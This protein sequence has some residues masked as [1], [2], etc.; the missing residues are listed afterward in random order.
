MEIKSIEKIENKEYPKINEISNKRLK[1]SI[2]QKWSRLGISIFIFNLI[3]KNKVF[4]SIN[5]NSLSDMDV[6][7]G[8][9]EVY[10]PTPTIV[11]FTSNMSFIISVISLM[12]MIIQKIKIKKQKEERKVSKILKVCFWISTIIFIISRIYMIVYES[13]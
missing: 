12:V 6:T 8:I 1:S 13:F 4:A 7:D 10:N 9:A 11:R 3:I 5:V 2:P